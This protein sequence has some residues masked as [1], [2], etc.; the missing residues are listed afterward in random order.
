M[1]S[2][3][4]G[5]VTVCGEPVRA[6]SLPSCFPEDDEAGLFLRYCPACVREAVRWVAGEPTGGEP[7]GDV[8][9]SH[10]VGLRREQRP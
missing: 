8:D 1:A 9:L 4:R 3:Y 2:P 5:Y 6:E 7:S 10:D